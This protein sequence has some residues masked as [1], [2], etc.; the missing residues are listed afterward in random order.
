MKKLLFILVTLAAAIL[1]TLWAKDD[2][3]Y[4]LID[5]KG[6]TIESSLV[7]AVIVLLVTF[8]LLHLGVRLYANLKSVGKGYR[9]WRNRRTQDK[10]N[11]FLIKGLLALSEGKWSE[12]EKDVLKYT[13][14]NQRR[15]GR[16]RNKAPTIGAMTILRALTRP[17]RMP[18]LPWGSPRRN[19]S[20]IKINWNKP[21]LL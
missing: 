16:R 8:V 7:F 17:P 5:V 21:W 1:V 12:A 11:E 20:W 2:P 13:D 6:Y 14:N 19:C 18:M 15:R 9:V 4:V 3:G 10:A